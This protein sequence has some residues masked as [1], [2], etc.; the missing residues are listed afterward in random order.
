MGKTT[1]L[2]ILSKLGAYTYDVDEFVHRIISN[3]LIIDQLKSVLGEDILIKDSVTP[4]IS[5]DG[6]AR[7]IFSDPQKRKA[8][9]SIIHP[10][11]LKEINLIKQKTLKKE[12]SA[13][14]VFEIPLLFEAGYEKNFDK[15]VVVFSD[16]DIAE[17]RLMDKG[18]TKD[19]VRQRM[20]A[21]MPV[22]RKKQKADYLIDNNGTVEETQR[23]VGNLFTKLRSSL[24]T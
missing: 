12:P 2:N 17:G 15:T 19:E 14:I 18:F 1:V 13:I 20:S 5:K 7:I 16:N 6:M 21:Q 9:E 10:E 11:V 24:Q 4:R 22:G 3:P 8:I 23:Q